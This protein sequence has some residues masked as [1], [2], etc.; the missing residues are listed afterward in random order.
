M[1]PRTDYHQLAEK[2]DYTKVERKLEQLREQDP[3]KKRKSAADL[4]DPVR[5]KLLA[6]HAQGWTYAQ[7]AEA[8]AESGLAVRAATLRGYLSRHGRKQTQRRSGRKSE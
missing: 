3:P 2:V 8:L 4:L 7:L 6:L 1:N 5:E